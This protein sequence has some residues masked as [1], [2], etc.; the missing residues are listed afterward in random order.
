M[1][2]ARRV[3]LAVLTSAGATLFAAGCVSTSASAPGMREAQL[4][5]HPADPSLLELARVEGKDDE[6]P[7]LV[8]YPRDA[9]SGS[10]SGVL[11]DDRGHYLG[12]IAPGTASLLSIPARLRTIHV[13]SS[14]EVT[15]PAGAWFSTDVVAVP[16]S[17]AGL[18]LRATRFS[19]RQCGSGQYLDVTAASKEALEHELE[20]SQVRWFV[21]G[22][23]EGQAWLD[24]HRARVDEVLGLEA[25]R[26]V[27]R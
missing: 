11:V 21:A 17:P 15:A 7:L 5:A 13:F 26:I 1:T 16:P 14:V 18:V 23:R 24:A 20:E 4:R 6:R 9:C 19:A 22:P 10:A 12:A 3:V 8:V 2:I 27:S 25:K